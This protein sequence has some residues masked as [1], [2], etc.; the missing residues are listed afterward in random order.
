MP[1]RAEYQIVWSSEKQGYEVIHGPFSFDL[2]NTSTLQY[3]MRQ[4]DTFHFCSSTGHT[5]T[6][7]KEPKQRGAGY[8]YGYKRVNGKVWK[9][10]FGEVSKIDLSILEQAARDCVEP[11]PPPQRKPTLHFDKTTQS[12]LHIFGFSKVPAK[13]ALITRYR[14]LSKQ[15][16]PDTGGLHEDM[17]AVNLAFDLLKRYV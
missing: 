12:A 5:L 9:R 10:Y 8:W 3:W 15:H 6:V 4:I 1:K 14:E 11:A 7:R 2:V 17:V 16:H 13:K